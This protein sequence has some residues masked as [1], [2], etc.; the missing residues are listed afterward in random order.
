MEYRISEVNPKIQPNAYKIGDRWCLEW[1][2]E[3]EN[4]ALYFVRFFKRKINASIYLARLK[5]NQIPWHT[6]MRFCRE[7]KSKK[8]TGS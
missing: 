2:V 3:K 6:Q 1:S 5:D 4:E 8:P 7:R